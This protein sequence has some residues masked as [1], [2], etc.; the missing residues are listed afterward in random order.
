M[1]M[2]EFWLKFHWSLFLKVQLT[3]LV[4]IMVWRRRGDKPL[5]EPMMTQ[6]N[7]AYMRHSVSMS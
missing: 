6:F 5:S 7:D 4:Q 1:E 3:I 2:F